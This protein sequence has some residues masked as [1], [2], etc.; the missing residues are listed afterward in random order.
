MTDEKPVKSQQMGR[1]VGDMLLERRAQL[2]EMMPRHLTPDRLI[3]VSMNC[4][5]KTP[6]LQQCTAASLMQCIITCAELGL[7]PGGALG[8]AYLVPFR[9][10]SGAMICTLIVGYRGLVELCRRS[11]QL[12]QIEAHVVYSADQFEMEFG[13]NP[14]LRH[15][16]SLVETPT[17]SKALLVYC[18]ARLKGGAVH[19]EFM[20]IPE[21]NSIQARSRSGGDGPW[22][23]DW[24]EMAK[25]SV[26]RRATK[27]MPMSEEV[28]RAIE[29]DDDFVE[30]LPVEAAPEPE[31]GTKTKR[32]ADGMRAKI[33]AIVDVIDGE[34]ELDAIR[35][36]TQQQE[37]KNGSEETGK[38][39]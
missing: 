19:V 27:L 32:I 37:P 7:E 5:A 35:R 38:A 9:D 23:T 24:A 39:G 36:T 26:I 28:S 20:T 14:K 22:K 1:I 30:S 34:S 6:K 18:V 33:S 3:K 4:I 15:V 25:K 16:P 21:V 31:A 29:A 12:E 2:A 13:L 17:Q 10:K 11:G 8:R